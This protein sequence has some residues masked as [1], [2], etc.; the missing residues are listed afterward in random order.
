LEARVGIEPT[1]E[2]FADLSLTTWLPRLK[3]EGSLQTIARHGGRGQ[4]LAGPP[5]TVICLL[6]LSGGWEGNTCVVEHGRVHMIV[7]AARKGPEG[8]PRAT[9]APNS[10]GQVAS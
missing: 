4:F 2:G 8:A 10:Y 6:D 9:L 7:N 1:N 5:Q 3:R